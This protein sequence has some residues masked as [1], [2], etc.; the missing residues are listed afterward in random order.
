MNDLQSKISSGP[1]RVLMFSQR[2]IY[3]PEAWRCSFA[4]FEKIVQQIDSVDMLAPKP[5]KYFQLRRNNAQRIGKFLTIVLN[6]GIPRMS[7]DQE[8]DL[9]LAVCEKPSELLIVDVLKGWK[10]KCRTSVCWLPEFWIK[11]IPF[12]KSAIKILSKFDHI[13]L[14]VA[15]TV[16][17]LS[18]AIE[19]ECFFLP[20]GIDAL[21]FSPYPNPPTRFIDVLSIGRRS[22]KTH[23]ALLRMARQNEIF[24]H[25]DTLRDLHVYDLEQHRLLMANMAKRSRYFIVNPGKIDTPDEIAGQIEFG[26]RYFEGAASGTILIG[27]Y[28]DSNEFQEFFHWPDAVI[29]L[30]FGS[31]RIGK[32]IKELDV[33][34]ARQEQIRR[35]NVSQ[36][37]LNHDWVYRWETILKTVGLEPNPGLLE[38]KRSLKELSAMIEREGHATA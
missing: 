15:R 9:F 28:P 18:N 10:E 17:P 23:E 26:Y 33:Q 4:E 19:K 8:Y 6:P 30:P 14:N 31:D 25:Y 3:K 1:A 22:E 5:G 2:N 34:P 35:T 20:G 24:Y 29:H 13:F 21:L 7:L 32:I 12:H 16:E 38:R 27:D 11:D 37:L 36:S